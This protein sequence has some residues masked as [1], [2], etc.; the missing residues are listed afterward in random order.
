MPMRRDALKQL[1]EY[2]AACSVA[3][4]LGGCFIV[5]EEPHR[6]GDG[7][8]PHNGYVYNMWFNDAAVYCQ[9]DVAEHISHWTLAANPD[10][11]YGIDEIEDVY[12]EIDGSFLHTSVSLFHLS[13]VGE[14]EWR[15]TFDNIGTPDNS[16]HCSNQYNFLFTAYDYDGHYT[17]TWVEW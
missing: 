7:F 6:G 12:A 5:L 8:G 9:Y 4:M 11:S 2:L 14:D 3:V 1:I 13:P 10:T 15:T 17:S 16:Y